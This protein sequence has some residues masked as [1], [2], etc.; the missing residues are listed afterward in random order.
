MV[1]GRQMVSVRD[2]VALDD[3]V[4]FSLSA[5]YQGVVADTW[6]VGLSCWMLGVGWSLTNL[7]NLVG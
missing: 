2:V 1:N 7:P 6:I 5:R 4:S 3:V